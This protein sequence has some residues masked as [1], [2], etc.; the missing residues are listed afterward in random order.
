MEQNTVCQAYHYS[1]LH[2]D[3][4]VISFIYLYMC[5]VKYYINT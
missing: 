4:V 3:L 1:W 2:T 5:S